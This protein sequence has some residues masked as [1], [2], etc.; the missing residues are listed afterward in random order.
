MTNGPARNKHLGSFQDAC[1]IYLM[2]PLEIG[3]RSGLAENARHP[4]TACDARAST[5][6]MPGLPDARRVRLS[7][8]RVAEP[9]QALFDMTFSGV[10][11][12]FPRPLRCR[13]P[14]IQSIR[15]GRHRPTLQLLNL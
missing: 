15:R 4:V 12:A 13:S 8:R 10:Q 9:L 14:G 7:G 5:Q 2:T 11:A 3:D 1:G 6:A